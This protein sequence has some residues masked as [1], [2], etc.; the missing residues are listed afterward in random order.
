MLVDQLLI[1]CLQMHKKT[2]KDRVKASFLSVLNAR[3]LFLKRAYGAVNPKTYKK[4]FQNREAMKEFF[5]EIQESILPQ[6]AD[7]ARDKVLEQFRVCQNRCQV[8]YLESGKLKKVAKGKPKPRAEKGEKPKEIG[9]KSYAAALKKQAPSVPK[10]EAKEPAQEPHGKSEKL[11]FECGSPEHLVYDCP[12]AKK[13]GK[14]KHVFIKGRR[15]ICVTPCKRKACKVCHREEQGLAIAKPVE[16]S[17]YGKYHYQAFDFQDLFRGSFTFAIRQ[18]RTVLLANYHVAIVATTFEFKGKRYPVP[19]VD[20]WV[21][22]ENHN[23]LAYCVYSGRDGMAPIKCADP[24]SHIDDLRTVSFVTYDAT[25]PHTP[26]SVAAC[27]YKTT[28]GD[29]EIRHDGNTTNGSCGSM[30]LTQEGRLLAIHNADVERGI[31]KRSRHPNSAILI[32]D[33]K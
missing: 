24:I 15:H 12:K 21:R 10:A 30:V 26:V 32:F 16:V 19:A 23:D 2:Q 20:Q 13:C 27:S 9:E 25:K 3:D 22:D 14:C 11:C 17:D 29:R 28:K 8:T 4:T 33:L 7:N 6:V 18:S 5:A 1:Q 31:Q